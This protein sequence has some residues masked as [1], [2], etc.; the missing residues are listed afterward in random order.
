MKEKVKSI[1]KITTILII[2]CILIFIIM[3]LYIIY[4][5]IQLNK[6]E[7]AIIR[8]KI[9]S[10]K[11]STISIMA[12]NNE[13]YSANYKNAK[14]LNRHGEVILVNELKNGYIEDITY[15]GII[16]AKIRSSL[17]DVKKIRVVNENI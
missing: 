12:E 16:N 4:N 7:Q 1:N 9:I 5:Y 14:I 2:V 8:G 13:E 3:F 17:I 6:E 11:E 15:S 10:I